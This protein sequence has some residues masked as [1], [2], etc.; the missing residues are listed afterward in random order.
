M[1]SEWLSSLRLR[2]RAIWK[3]S[4]LDRDLQEEMAF[5]LAMREEKLRAI[6]KQPDEAHYAAQRA[7]GNPA[8][9][10]EDT[11]IL[12]TF[13]WLEDL[14]QDLRFGIRML[15]K[16]P[17]FTLLAVFTLALGIGASTA[18]F[19]IS[20]AL[21]RK[22]PRWYRSGAV[23]GLE[24]E[25]NLRIFNFSVPEFVEL[26]SLHDVFE[27]AGALFWSNSTI[28]TGEYP[29]H[30]GCA[31]VSA[32]EVSRVQPE[33]GRFF[34][35]DEDRPGGPAVAVLSDEFWHAYF[36]ADRGILGKQIRLDGRMYTVIGI[37]A[38][39]ESRF[40]SGVMVPAQLDLADPDRSHRNLWVLVTLRKNVSWEQAD[41]RLMTLAQ[42]IERE[43]RIDHP[44][45]AGQQL[46][47]WNVYEAV[48][49]GIRPVLLILLCAVAL[50]W[51]ICC[52]NVAI[53]LLARAM[54]RQ[55]EL[56][57]RAAL[58]ESR[59]AL[60]Q[61]LLV[62]SLLLATV[63]GA[64]GVLV[65]RWCLPAL[66]HLIPSPWLTA[67]PD[68]I[69]INLH[70]LYVALGLTLFTS[71]ASGL[72]PAWLSSQT[73]IAEV[74][75]QAGSRVASDQRGRLTRNVLVVTQIAVTLLVLSGAA[76]TS[77]SYRNLQ[78]VDLGFH[79]E[80]VLSLQIS[81]PDS[82]YPGSVQIGSFFREAIERVKAL[83]G[84]DGAAVVLGLPMLDRTVDV[85]TRDLTIEGRPAENVGGLTN[86]NF[87]IASPGYFDVIGARLIRGRLF[88][89]QDGPGS[90]PV[91]LINE[92]MARIYWPNADPIGGRI[93]LIPGNET[94]RTGAGDEATVTVVGVVSDIKQIR[95]IDAPVRQEF[96]LS[97]AQFAS[98]ARGLTMMVRSSIEPSTLTLS[99]RNVI[100]AIDPEQPVYAV[101]PMD[102]VVADSFGP[103]RIATVL[104]AFF[105]AA[106]VVLS[107]IGI[108]AIL[109]YSVS[110]RTREMSLRMALGARPND[111]LR[112]IVW[113][114]LSLAFAGLAL[115]IGLTAALL[116]L[117]RRVSYGVTPVG[118]F[119]GV[120]PWN[121]ARFVIVGA[122]LLAVALL[123]CYLPARRAV[124]VDPIIALQ[125]A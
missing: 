61:Q 63:G 6:G 106:A 88:T 16:T 50:L 34:R 70:V 85:A 48:T 29:E 51:T 124:R 72:A 33:L 45:Y 52:A 8:K 58:G 84:V 119:Y 49:G 101:E 32:S 55:R 102:Q 44:E 111:I 21:L 92:T 36:A 60:V 96:Y 76:L 11:R 22:D 91:T 59:P 107:C 17:T 12:W 98:V 99:I 69:R 120:S 37:T 89:D 28:T 125:D 24:P 4:Q 103:K 26:S 117:T 114:G 112:L 62:E 20:D 1:L 73:N 121:P 43:H 39:H 110:Q 53:L 123:A 27:G 42:D 105:A 75:K 100:R 108:Y 41:A 57:M 87:R 74:L 83:P 14:G 15:R 78:H 122:V 67:S 77:Q 94:G 5:H 97:Q 18:L 40:D 10:K 109:S 2:L 23:I 35:P 65:S 31:H 46:H 47:F 7:F 66:V 56:A 81:L 90:P 116:A 9:L 71:L 80:H 64:A 13:R 25:R 19:S 95:V 3:R 104:L 82:K 115:G 113:N 54:M 93:H 68:Q 30:V 38:P 86:A 118:I 79:P